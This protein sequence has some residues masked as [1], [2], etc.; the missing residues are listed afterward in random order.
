MSITKKLL[1]HG[2]IYGVARVATMGAPYLLLPLFA[3][4]LGDTGLGKIEL[5]GTASLFIATMLLQGQNAAWVRLRFEY[6]E[7]AALA[8]FDA[9]LTYYLLASNLVLVGL[10]TLAGPWLA[11]WITPGI[12]F[13]PLGFLAVLAAATTSFHTLVER[14]LQAERRPVAF[15]VFSLVK[16]CLSVGVV[17][18][19]VAGLERGVLGKFEADVLWGVAL[20]ITAFVVIRPGSPRRASGAI[21]RSTLTYGLPLVPHALTHLAGGMFTRLLLNGMLGVGAVGV[22]SMG[23]RLAM[24]ANVVATALNQAFGPLFIL[25]LKEAETAAPEQAHR[26]RAD[27]GRSSLVSIVLVSSAALTISAWGRELIAVIAT[28]K[29]EESW[30]VLAIINASSIA[31]AVYLPFSQSVMQSH[32][33][34]RVLPFATL[35][36]VVTVVLATLLLVPPF[37]I[38]GAAWATLAGAVVLAAMGYWLGQHQVRIP[39]QRGR[40]WAV[41]VTAI[42]ALASLAAVDASEL[43]GV[44]RLA[45]KTVL[46]GGA[47]GILVA[48]GGGLRVVRRFLKSK[49]K[50]SVKPAAFVDGE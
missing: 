10:L 33:G 46:L 39:L 12:D 6:P 25:A 23:L 31:Y 13:F 48:A 40:W 37:G 21:L 36:S 5:L 38:V 41:L 49:P 14:K 11:P 47:V 22:Y 30:R 45:I 27:L 42:V 50:R 4:Y 3:R 16:V 7:R 18:A 19:F 15:A 32:R 9:T 1:G 35:A 20:A 34:T 17:A 8:A 43:P 28:P 24:V 44:E 29:F 26:I 2:A